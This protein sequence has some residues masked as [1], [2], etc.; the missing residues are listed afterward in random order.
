MREGVLIISLVVAFLVSIPRPFVG[1]L[2]IL[3]AAV[4]RDTLIVET[5]GTFLDYHGYEVLYLGAIIGVL[6]SSEGRVVG[7]MPRGLCDWGML[8]FLLAMIASYIANGLPIEEIFDHKYIDLF[9]KA[10]VLYFLLS[11]LTDTPRR[12]M[13]MAA[14]LILATSYLTY[15]AWRNYREGVFADARPY[16]RTQFHEFGLQLVITLPLIGALLARRMNIL[17]RLFLFAMIPL[18]VLVALRTHSRSAYLGAG[19]GLLLLAWYYRRRWYLQILALPIVLYA[20]LHQTQDVRVRVE[21]IW[22][23]KTVEG[24]EDTSINMRLEQM[25]TAMRV[26]SAHPVFGV[27]PRQF[28]LKYNDFVS[29]EDWRDWTYT[30]HSVPLLILCEEGV[31]GFIMFYGFLVLGALRAAAVV[32]KRVR[33]RPELESTAI[34][35][36][37]AAMSFL[38]FSA[39]S[40][41]QPAMWTIN[42]YGTVALVVAARRVVAAFLAEEAAQTADEED[43]QAVAA[44]P[45]MTTEVAFP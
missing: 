7:F 25:R 1:V 19:F 24:T 10:T 5:W 9:F 35:G 21:S 43:G 2:L 31:L 17:F 4:L 32:A 30:M 28:F 42:I 45:G 27:G 39:F 40:L 12:V 8:G 22:T 44:A 34:V 3:A 20:V 33:G 41:G 16:G 14:V 15:K 37:G 6:V 29:P 23:H 26:I 38:A 13:L 18:Y 36:A 11:R